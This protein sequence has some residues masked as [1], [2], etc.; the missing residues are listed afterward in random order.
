MMGWRCWRTPSIVAAVAIVCTV[1]LNQNAFGDPLHGEWKT[2]RSTGLDMSF[3]YPENWSVKEDS[4]VILVS[5]PSSKD[6]DVD[7]VQVRLST[8]PLDA[9]TSPEQLVYELWGGKKNFESYEANEHLSCGVVAFSDS[10]KPAARMSCLCI[11]SPSALVGNRLMYIVM[12]FDSVA[13]KAKNRF[14]LYTWTEYSKHKDA[15][16]WACIEEVKQ[17][18]GSLADSAN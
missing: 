13:V 18:V 16:K 11:G 15:N 9:A 5:S 17:I 6:P 12:A 7:E 1:A 4:G 2:Y 8:R 14:L 3:K 10:G